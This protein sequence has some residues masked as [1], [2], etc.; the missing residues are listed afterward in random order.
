MLRLLRQL[1]FPFVLGLFAGGLFPDLIACRYNVRETGFV[2]F[3]IDNYTLFIRAEKDASPDDVTRL[4]SAV[5]AALVDS[6]VSSRIIGA[7][8]DLGS[9]LP[10]FVQS[11]PGAA[12]D[13]RAVLLSPMGRHLSLGDSLETAGSSDSLEL[14]L[15]EVASSPI[16][17]GITERIVADYAVILLIEGSQSERNAEAYQKVANTVAEIAKYLKYMPK[18]IE[19]GPSILKMSAEASRNERVL[20]WSLGLQEDDLESPHVAVLYGKVR[21]IGPLL[22][23]DE[24]TE[25]MLFRIL[26]LVGAD[27]ECGLDTRLLRGKMLP[28]TWRSGIRARVAK[29]LGF[30]PEN[31]MVATEVSQILRM[32]ALLW[33]EFEPSRRTAADFDELPVPFVDD[34]EAEEQQAFGFGP[35][36]LMAGTIALVAVGIGTAV[37][38]V[39]IRKSL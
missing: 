12:N 7:D 16:R 1:L 38:I 33:P 2:D 31:P 6:N 15:K 27:C 37:L 10:S 18:P 28:V 35:V 17:D 14:L 9:L 5:T 22:T 39:A 4:E 30:D 24:I 8:A 32:R 36:I 11:Q 3:G 19:R 21:W 26:S 13:S 34:I 20:L 29:N 25:E 23:G